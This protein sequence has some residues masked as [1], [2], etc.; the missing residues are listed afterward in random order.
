MRPYEVMFI[1]DP[2]AVADDAV[3]SYIQR[4]TALL[5]EHG[6]QVTGVD[7]WGKRRFAYE[8]KGRTEGYYVV[9]TFQAS[10]EAVAEL[11]RVMRITDHLIRHI[12][13]RRDEFVKAGAAQPEAAAEAPAAS[14]ER[15]RGRPRRRPPGSPPRKKAPQSPEK[16]WQ[17]KR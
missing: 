9:M 7:K 8:I 1:L 11:N 16:Q 6:G 12:V 2:V 13:V 14:S 15:G 4:F 10:R 17:R 5:A 3:D